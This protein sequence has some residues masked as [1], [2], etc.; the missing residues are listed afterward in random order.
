M[1][2]AISASISPRLS[3]GWRVSSDQLVSPVGRLR[4]V[5]MLVLSGLTISDKGLVKSIAPTCA[6]AIQKSA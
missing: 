5:S 3:F 2:S 1:V 4:N 6:L